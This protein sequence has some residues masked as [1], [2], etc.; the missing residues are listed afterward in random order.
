MEASN[1]IIIVAYLCRLRFVTH[2]LCINVESD[3]QSYIVSHYCVLC[4]IDIFK[5]RPDHT[6]SNR[7][8]WNGHFNCTC[9]ECVNDL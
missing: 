3:H 7:Q 9:S 5:E 2:V 6:K 1:A 4:C 8:W